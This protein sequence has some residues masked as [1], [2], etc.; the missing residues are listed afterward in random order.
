MKSAR[1]L[2]PRCVWA[3]LLVSGVA[4]PAAAS[5]YD[6]RLGLQPP[7]PTVYEPATLIIEGESTNGCLPRFEKLTVEGR[8]V[9]V[10]LYH[11]Q[12][13]CPMVLLPWTVKVDLGELPGGNY[14]VT[15]R[16]DPFP[17]PSKTIGILDFVVSA[18]AGTRFYGIRSSRVVCRNVTSGQQVFV[19]AADTAAVN[20]EAAGLAIA[21]GDKVMVRIVGTVP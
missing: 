3:F 16:T 9:D 13:V 11:R 2:V 17:L 6:V 18:P 14:S 15:V 7:A 5:L 1:R 8:T 21:P 12:T 4:A 19:R 10:V 20:C